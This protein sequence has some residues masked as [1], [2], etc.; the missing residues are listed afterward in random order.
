MNEGEETPLA[1]VEDVAAERDAVVERVTEH[2][3]GMASELARIDGGDYGSRSFSTD[4]G[5]WTLKYEAGTVQYLRFEGTSGG[6][7]YVVSEHRSPDPGA[8]ARAMADYGAFAEAFDEYVRSLDGLLADV[9]G[10]FPEVRS[11]A[12]VA[13]ERDRIA[14][15]M[16]EATDAMAGELHRFEG[17]QYGT[18]AARVG[19]TRWEL[20]RERERTSYLRVGGEDGV[21]LLSQYGPASAADM[22]ALVEDF[23]PFVEAF[24]DH[25]E[26]LEAD[27]SRV[28]FD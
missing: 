23:A 21:Y 9:P 12:A 15:R 16:R 10:E 20:K 22:R 25:V 2:A 11:A 8:L 1:G 7:T 4:R 14:D 18:F 27:L 3:G 26:S 6:E 17:E 19:G 13:A 24:N 5:K 28:T